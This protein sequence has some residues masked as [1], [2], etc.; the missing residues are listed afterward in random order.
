MRTAGRAL[1]VATALA[2]I[3]AAPALASIA[4]P[5][6]PIAVL[7]LQDQYLRAGK[8]RPLYALFTARFRSACPY[9]KFVRTARQNR[10]ALQ[11][12]RI[13]VD[14][15]RIQGT[16]ALVNYRYV[17]RGK[18]LATVRGDVYVRV[19]GRWY[20]ERDRYTTCE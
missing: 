10:A 15:Q 17:H 5:A 7:R 16:R 12:V 13:V 18:V 4:A 6:T 19:G 11:G 8:F 20:D 9:A 14:G 3:A 2:A 1:A